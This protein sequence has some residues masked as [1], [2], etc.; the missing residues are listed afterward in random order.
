MD[1]PKYPI[2][3]VSRVTWVGDGSV[4]IRIPAKMAHSGTFPF[5]KNQPVVVTVESDKRVVITAV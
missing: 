2:S 3:D 5:K 1:E 4:Y